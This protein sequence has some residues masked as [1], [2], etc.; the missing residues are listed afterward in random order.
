MVFRITRSTPDERG[1]NMGFALKIPRVGV[2][3]RLPNGSEAARILRLEEYL[4]GDPR[5]LGRQRQRVAT[6]PGHR[7]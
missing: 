5:P 3:V 6:G 2:R 4:T 7:A 1:Q